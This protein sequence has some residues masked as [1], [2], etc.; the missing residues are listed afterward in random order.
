MEFP[1]AGCGAQCA[2]ARL[3]MFQEGQ[4]N[5]IWNWAVHRS[6]ENGNWNPLSGA[7]TF[8]IS[9]HDNNG[10]EK[11][12]VDKSDKHYRFPRDRQGEVGKEGFNKCLTVNTMR[13]VGS[14]KAG[15]MVGDK[16]KMNMNDVAPPS[17]RGAERNGV[18]QLPVGIS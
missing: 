16:K 10:N 18:Q 4:K 17:K 11:K 1:L 7:H 6:S 2:R 15:S 9:W 8:A 5:T 13:F 14:Q 12:S 3:T